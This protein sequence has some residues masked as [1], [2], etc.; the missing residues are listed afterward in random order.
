MAPLSTSFILAGIVHEVPSPPGIP[1][2]FFPPSLPPSSVPI[3][4]PNGGPTIFYPSLA[5]SRSSLYRASLLA[6]PLPLPS[7]SPS[8]S[9]QRPRQQPKR[10]DRCAAPSRPP[11]LSNASA[12]VEFGIPFSAARAVDVVVVTRNAAAN[13]FV[14]RSIPPLSR[15]SIPRGS[16]FAVLHAGGS[17]YRARVPRVQ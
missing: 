12:F 1:P 3:H 14:A 13:A 15:L 7:L 17:V 5:R 9:S 10:A 8:H 6:P 4:H 16:T 11:L 2:P